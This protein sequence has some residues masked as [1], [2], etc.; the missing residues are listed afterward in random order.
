MGVSRLLCLVG[1]H[2]WETVTDAGG[3]LTTCTRCGKKRHWV[4]RPPRRVEARTSQSQLTLA[5][6]IAVASVAVDDCVQGDRIRGPKPAL[7]LIRGKGASAL[8]DWRLALPGDPAKPQRCS[9]RVS[10][11][12]PRRGLVLAGSRDRELACRLAGNS[13]AYVRE[14]PARTDVRGLQPGLRSR[15]LAEQPYAVSEHD[16]DDLHD[17]LV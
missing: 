17:D 15:R 2:H 4:T 14:R 16:R 3:A 8:A 1:S 13:K 6:P 5:G 7:A 12:G 11:R 9:R 10:R